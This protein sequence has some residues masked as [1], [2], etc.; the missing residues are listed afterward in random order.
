MLELG[1]IL[2]AS[3]MTGLDAMV[4]IVCGATQTWSRVCHAVQMALPVHF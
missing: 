4:P 3:L 1:F 2:F